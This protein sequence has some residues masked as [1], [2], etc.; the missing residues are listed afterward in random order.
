[1][2]TPAH[3]ILGAAAFG[4]PGNMRVTVAAVLG[5]LAPDISL[6]AMVSWSIFV[7]GIDPNVVFGEFYYS[8]TWQQVFAVDNSFVLW[9]LGLGFALWAARPVFIAF[10][11][12]GLLHLVFDF[13]LHNHDARMHFWPL[14]DWVFVS[15]LS[16]WDSRF[17][18]GVISPIELTLA[19][20]LAGSLFC[21]FR[22]RSARALIVF[23]AGMEI[24]ATRAFSWFF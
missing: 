12:A 22:R 2:N 16:Y 7:A 15:P 4:K 17:H 9:G 8:S 20:V 19:L 6:Y 1:M 13:P 3:L 14:T 23:A 11:G 18:A 5:S 10:A 24:L 21:R